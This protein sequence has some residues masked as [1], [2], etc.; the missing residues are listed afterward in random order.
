MR[1]HRQ[2]PLHLTLTAHLEL[3][4]VGLGFLNLPLSLASM[5]GQAVPP[6]DTQVAGLPV[7]HEWAQFQEVLIR[8]SSRWPLRR[9]RPVHQ[10]AG[11]AVPTL[12]CPSLMVMG[13]QMLAGGASQLVELSQT[14]QLLLGPLAATTSINLVLD[15]GVH[16]LS[17]GRLR[18]FLGISSM[19]TRSRDQMARTCVKVQHLAA[20]LREGTSLANQTCP[21]PQAGRLK[22]LPR[23]R[24]GRFHHRACGRTKRPQCGSL[25]RW[26]DFHRKVDPLFCQPHK[27]TI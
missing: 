3:P 6:P 4:S 8:D 25:P 11:V 20:F 9:T 22:A 1:Q 21:T 23:P 12:D 17:M 27:V 24:H 19:L 13:M 2:L 7:F 14:Q 5:M 15:M 16:F 18:V 10:A 26:L